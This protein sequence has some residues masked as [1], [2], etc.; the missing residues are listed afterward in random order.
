MFMTLSHRSLL[1]TAVLLG[2][3]L[4]SFDSE[5]RRTGS[6]HTSGEAAAPALARSAVAPV[7]QPA[8]D[9]E[10]LRRRSEDNLRRQ[11]E[12]DEKIRLEKEKRAAAIAA[13]EEYQARQRALLEKER[14]EKQARNRAR[15]SANPCVYKPVMSDEDLE[16]CRQ[17]SR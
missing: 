4:A 12:A 8:A 14:A 13:W 11:A 10:E 7:P 6:A 5:A 3:L 17:A 9:D 16:R 15:E 2:M 1:S